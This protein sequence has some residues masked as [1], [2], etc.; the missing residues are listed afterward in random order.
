[1][2]ARV[3]SATIANVQIFQRRLCMNLS[4]LSN[5]NCRPEVR[6][7]RFYLLFGK[8]IEK[9]ISRTLYFICQNNR[10]KLKQTKFWYVS[11][12]EFLGRGYGCCTLELTGWL[13]QRKNNR[14]YSR[15]LWKRKKYEITLVFTFQRPSVVLS[16]ALF[17]V[18]AQ[19]RWVRSRAWLAVLWK[20]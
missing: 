8:S 9:I 4:E 18:G 17:P 7:F 2:N 20:L 12:T 16:K 1:M 3:R 5:A 15:W 11:C 14:L 13:C 10:H 19:E 6:W